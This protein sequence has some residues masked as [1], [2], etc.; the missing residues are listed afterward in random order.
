MS[1]L[2]CLVH[3]YDIAIIHAVL[4]MPRFIRMVDTI[5]E[6]DLMFLV[7]VLFA[8]AFIASMPAAYIADRF[9][10]RWTILGGCIFFVAGSGIQTAA[11]SRGT[12]LAGRAVAGVGI[13]IMTLVGMVYLSEI[14]RPSMRGVLTT[15]QSFFVVKGI[16]VAAFIIYSVNKDDQGKERQY[17]LPLALVMGPAIF[18][19][20]LIMFCPE[21]PR[22]LMLKGREQDA[23]RALAVSQTNCNST[24]L[25]PCC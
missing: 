23:T 13:G 9:G 19:G 15:L 8:G 18:L 17:K 25:M 11:D 24:E 22:W 10:R 5:D 7:V 16:L 6:D 20:A 4:R 21:S 14:A 1:L 12:F 3:S 2:L